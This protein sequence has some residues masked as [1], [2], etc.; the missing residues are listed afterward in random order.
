MWTE[1]TMRLPAVSVTP[2]TRLAPLFSACACIFVHEIREVGLAVCGHRSGDWCVAS[3]CVAAED[4]RQVSDIR[5]AARALPQH[6]ASGERHVGR[7][8]Q[9]SQPDPRLAPDPLPR[10]RVLTAALAGDEAG[11]EDRSDSGD[12]RE[13]DE[14][15]E[16]SA[17][18]TKA[19]PG[20]DNQG[21]ES[22]EA[23]S[24]GQREAR[25]R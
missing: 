17:D 14:E 16:E 25:D 20:G 7:Q 22:R 12:Q 9:R 24:E 15:G 2:R 11:E 3:S 18:A 21:A 8:C 5:F 6:A 23:S 4:A 13:E 19:S 10:S 1:D